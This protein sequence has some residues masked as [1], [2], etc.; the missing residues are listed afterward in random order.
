MAGRE[1]VRGSLGGI[2]F[3]VV[4]VLVFWSLNTYRHYRAGWTKPQK[5]MDITGIVLLTAVSALILFPMIK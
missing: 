1:N 3:L 2:L 4:L 5:I